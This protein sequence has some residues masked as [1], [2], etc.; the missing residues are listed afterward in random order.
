MR[1]NAVRR[2]KL[3]EN[4]RPGNRLELIRRTSTRKARPLLTIAANH[5]S[6][7]AELGWSSRQGM[8]EKATAERFAEAETAV[9]AEVGGAA[10]LRPNPRDEKT[11]GQS[12]AERP[13]PAQRA[14]RRNTASPLATLAFASAVVAVL[15]YA[16]SLRLERHITADTGLGYGLGI[17]GGLMLLTLLLYPL[18]KNLKSMRGLGAVPKWF[19]MHMVFGILGPA[20]IV[21]HSNFRLSAI[22]ST[23]AMC[24][25]LTVVA[26]GLIGRFLYSRVHIGLYGQ[27]AEL[28]AL[29]ADT[30]TFRQSF[31]AD[32]EHAPAL[33]AKLKVAEDALFS[34]TTSILSSLAALFGLI[35][36]R[37]RQHAEL[38]H[39]AEAV[40][41][42]AALREHWDREMLDWR[43]DAARDHLASYQ[44]CL[45]KAAGF[46]V[47]ERLFSYWHHLHMPLYFLL[48]VTALLHV[49]TV[50]LY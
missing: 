2:G 50:H 44:T 6:L 38:L 13:A 34:K 39:E 17:A 9:R 28:T 8:A 27:K 40:L 45:V 4:R 49:V 29:R 42:A 46:R 48:I 16:W 22:N 32:I 35:A 43:L 1:C 11:S 7:Q 19:R 23:V 31:G 47:Y 21:L 26:S 24:A 3:S 20:L 36:S 5:Q 37:R 33:E 18:R 12:R 15:A 41:S 30:E 10:L 14:R 25:M